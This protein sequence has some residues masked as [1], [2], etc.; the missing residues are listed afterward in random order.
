MYL[1]NEL[2][3]IFEEHMISMFIFH[4]IN[5]GCNN[6]PE[7]SEDS[8]LAHFWSRLSGIALTL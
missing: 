5:F 6:R 2:N 8:E 7:V 1:P 3:R 4:N